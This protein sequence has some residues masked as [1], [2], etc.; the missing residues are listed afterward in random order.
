MRQATTHPPR[1]ELRRGV[2]SPRIFQKN[3]GN[4]GFVTLAARHQKRRFVVSVGCAKQARNN[5]LVYPLY[6][7]LL[8]F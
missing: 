5:A 3:E 2:V 7:E 8:F 1:V 6:C 4:A